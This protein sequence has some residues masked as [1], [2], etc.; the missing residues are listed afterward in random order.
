[1]RAKK[2]SRTE[3]SP[4]KSGTCSWCGEITRDFNFNKACL[5]ARAGVKEVL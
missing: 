3:F 2:K 4:V 1:M 5:A